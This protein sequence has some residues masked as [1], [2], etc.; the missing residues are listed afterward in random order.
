MQFEGKAIQV[1]EIDSGL[2]ELCFDL[3]NEPVNK[4]NQL[5][6]RELKEAV[7][8]LGAVDG[9]KGVLFSSS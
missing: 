5:T 7:T 9:I 8:Q 1:Q 2:Y 3:N 4:F 6:L